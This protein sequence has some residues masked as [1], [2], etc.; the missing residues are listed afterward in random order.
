MKIEDNPCTI[1]LKTLDPLHG[2]LV[3]GCLKPTDDGVTPITY[4]QMEM[5]NGMKYGKGEKDKPHSHSSTIDSSYT[6]A[7][8]RLVGQSYVRRLKR[9]LK[10]V[11]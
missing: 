11:D 4:A 9:R 2:D 1:V 8:E 3:G 10:N 7:E 6:S 5:G